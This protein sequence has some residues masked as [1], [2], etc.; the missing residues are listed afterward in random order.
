MIRQS[1]IVIALLALVSPLANA[2]TPNLPLQQ[3]Q[4]PTQPEAPNAAT[5]T[6][7]VVQPPSGGDSSDQRKMYEDIAIMRELLRSDLGVLLGLRMHPDGSQ[8]GFAFDDVD[9]DG[10]MDLYMASDATEGFVEM[11]RAGFA[12]G[13]ASLAGRP[14]RPADLEGVYIEGQGV[15]YSVAMTSNDPFAVLPTAA[16]ATATKTCVKCHSEPKQSEQML[17][18]MA[19][20]PSGWELARRRLLGMETD[21]RDKDAQKTEVKTC[22]PGAVSEVVLRLLAENGHNFSQLGD[23]EKLAVAITFRRFPRGHGTRFSDEMG[24]E[25]S[26]GDMMSMSEF[27]YG[28][29][30]EEGGSSYGMGQPMASS[31]ELPRTKTRRRADGG[32]GS[33]ESMEDM[34]AYDGVPGGDSAR[35][36]SGFIRMP[37]PVRD[38][39]LLGDLHMKQDKHRDALLAY[40]RALEVASA[41]RDDDD[42]ARTKAARLAVTANVY[43]KLAQASLALGNLKAAKEWLDQSLAMR[44]QE[45]EST[46]SKPASSPVLPTKLIISATKKLLDG[47]G[48]GDVSLDEFKEAATVEH[49][50]FDRP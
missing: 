17:S 45:Q 49:L 31:M 30:G 13:G 44:K 46:D 15:L 43:Q 19:K 24:S 2:Q 9:S 35:H 47:V 5:L 32:M 33:M 48:S 37:P 39:V 42:T 20:L 34:G 36:A 23:D 12:A 1:T 21:D 50:T 16:R 11:A 28:T 10:Y 22:R 40:E 3:A 26:M 18:T 6:P 27:D 29:L 8:V 14:N 41:P 38:H 7:V 25:G 4:G